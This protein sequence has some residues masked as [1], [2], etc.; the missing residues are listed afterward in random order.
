MEAS[1]R[2]ERGVSEPVLSK[3][4]R[5]VTKGEGKQMEIQRMALV[6][7]PIFFYHLR[8]LL[9][10]LRLPLI[11]LLSLPLCVVNK[12]VILITLLLLQNGL[13][14]VTCTV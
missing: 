14:R 5:K 12:S 7:R 1:K 11:C 3:N 6:Q 9:S 8:F 4:D 10:P 2:K 13:C